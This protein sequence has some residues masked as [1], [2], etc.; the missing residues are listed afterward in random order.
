MCAFTPRRQVL[1][2]RSPVIARCTFPLVWAARA[3]PFVDGAG[4]GEGGATGNR[5]LEL[6]GRPAVAGSAGVRVAELP[7][8]LAP[9]TRAS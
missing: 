2:P 3:G 8:A 6:F 7:A 5:Q 9:R 1:E 4:L